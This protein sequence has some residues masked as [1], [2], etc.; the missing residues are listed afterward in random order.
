MKRAK[1]A[2]IECRQEVENNTD[3]KRRMRYRGSGKRRGVIKDIVFINAE[4]VLC[5]YAPGK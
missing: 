1:Q 5:L 2:G 4:E 3:G